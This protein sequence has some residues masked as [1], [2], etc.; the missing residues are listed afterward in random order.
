MYVLIVLDVHS[1]YLLIT[2]D[3]DF[4]QSKVIPKKRQIAY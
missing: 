2:G 1:A 3:T 4:Y